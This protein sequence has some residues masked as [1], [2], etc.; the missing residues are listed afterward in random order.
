MRKL[1]LTIFSEGEV[2]RSETNDIEVKLKFTPKGASNNYKSLHF[3]S[4]VMY[5]KRHPLTSC[6]HLCN[7]ETNDLILNLTPE[8]RL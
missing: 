2:L 4:T 7:N 3:L 8:N 1:I 5:F 6:S